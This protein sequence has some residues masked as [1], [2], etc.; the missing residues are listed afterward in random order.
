[1]KE[2]IRSTDVDQFID[3]LQ[4]ATDRGWDDW[5]ALPRVA[6]PTLVLTG[7][8]EDPEDGTAEA[9]ARMPNAT[10]IR[11]AGLG[12]INAFLASRLVPARVEDF[13]ARFAS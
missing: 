13:L 9:V 10:R 5:E 2:R 8:L 12:H 6:A 1:M 3:Y 7:E 4:A 11:L